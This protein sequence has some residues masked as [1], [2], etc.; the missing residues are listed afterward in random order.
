M[1]GKVFKAYDV[2]A[3]YPRP[4]NEKTAWLIGHGAATYLLEK[5]RDTGRLDP[6][7]R[8]IVVGRDC[9]LSSPSLADALSNGIRKA[10]GHVLD[11]GEVDT[12]FVYFAINHLDA[13]GGVQVTASHNPANY[14]GFKI[15][16]LAAKPIGDG[17]GL[18]D[19]RR[20][21]AMA[22]PDRA[23]GEGNFEERDLWPAYRAWLLER[24][25]PAILD[26]SASLKIVVDA[27]NGMAGAMVPKVFGK[28]KGL[29]LVLLNMTMDGTFAHE[30]NPLV[31]K[32]MVPTQEAVRE[33]GADFGV[34][35]DGDADRCVVVDETGAT[36]PC[37]LLL[38]WLVG[39]VLKDHPRA[40]VVHDIRS[41][42]AVRSAI[43]AAGGTPIESRVGHVFMKAALAEHKAIIGG[44]VS[45]HFYFQDMF[46]TDSGARA[47][48]EV[49]NQLLADGGPLSARIAPHDTYARTGELNFEVEDIPEAIEAVAK[50]FSE[51]TRREFDGMGLD[52]GSWWC[53]IRASNTEPL[54]RLNLEAKD[55]KI[56]DATRAAFEEVL[57]APVDH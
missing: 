40:A 32:N 27:S 38:A 45:G 24:L 35:F 30:P 33:H 47:F 15:S 53:T 14:N 16:G 12:P 37:D 42:R 52:A 9:R 19:I 22:N 56:L 55:S 23:A 26:G 57:G 17:S 4:L 29:D 39:G 21:S 41:S 51:A 5:A 44:E 36:V 3:T 25:S 6:M 50:R 48:V 18:E 43:E 7:A 49:C 8:H 20:L 2:R 1:L 54:L 31:Q 34:C 11:V 46:N 10:G 28:V 13:A